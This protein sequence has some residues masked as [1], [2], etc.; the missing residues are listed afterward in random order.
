MKI[1]IWKSLSLLKSFCFSCGLIKQ[2]FLFFSPVFAIILL[3]KSYVSF[4][5]FF[6]SFLLFK[7]LNLWLGI[8][9]VTISSI[10]KAMTMSIQCAYISVSPF[11]F[12][13]LFFFMRSRNFLEKLLRSIR[14]T[15]WLDRFAPLETGCQVSRDT[16]RWKEAGFLESVALAGHI[17][18]S[19][20]SFP[21][22]ETECLKLFIVL[23]PML[24]PIQIIA[25]INL[26]K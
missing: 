6:F 1:I 18:I 17:G 20:Y 2:L 10:D 7:V 19:L 11:F 9:N 21:F 8:I 15:M 3:Y 24:G 12:L 16:S 22:F 14:D 26:N 25:K 23:L 5:S 13:F 4:I